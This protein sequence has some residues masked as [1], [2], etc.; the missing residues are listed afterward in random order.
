MKTGDLVTSR[1]EWWRK[2]RCVHEVGIVIDIEN[3]PGLE[4]RIK[5]YWVDDVFDGSIEWDWENDLEVVKGS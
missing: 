3:L 1:A 5:V 4:P 2:E